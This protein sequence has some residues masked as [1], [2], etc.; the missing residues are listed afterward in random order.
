M[1]SAIFNLTA[2]SLVI[3]LCLPRVTISITVLRFG[4]P[5]L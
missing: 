1:V 4:Y 5:I 3:Y 2:Y